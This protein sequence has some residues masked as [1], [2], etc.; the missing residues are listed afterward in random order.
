[1]VRNKSG[2]YKSTMLLI[3]YSLTR[4]IFIDFVG[5]LIFSEIIA[6]ATFPFFR[7]NIFLKKYKGL[8]IVLKGLSILLFFQIISDLFN[9]TSSS[10]FLRGWAVIFF[11]F[12]SVVFLVKNIG[13]NPKA[14][15]PLLFC[16][17][18]IELI[19]GSTEL[20]IGLLE[21]N[22]NFFKVRF[23]SFL[24]L[25]VL[26]ISYFF[27]VKR[28][29]SLVPIL[30]LTYALI[31]F[32][33]DARSNGLIFLIASFLMFTKIRKV[34][35]SKKNILIIGVI[36][37]VF[38]YSSYVFYVNSVINNGFGGR[39]A[40]MQ[41]SS[42][43]NPYNPF[44]LLYKG[45][46]ETFIAIIAIQEKPVLGHGSWAKDKGGKYAYLIKQIT[47]RDRNE[48]KGFIPSHSVL[49]GSWLYAGFFGF[50][51]ILYLFINLFK[52]YFKIFKSSFDS[53]VFPIITVLTADMFWAVLF[54]PFGLL[55]TTFP[56]FAAMLIIYN[57]KHKNLLLEKL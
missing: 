49:L 21:E 57:E 52:I 46:L 2:K 17:F 15:I 45:R 31:C 43:D 50:L 47:G 33:L 20:D 6:L 24:N 35:F 32:I 38:F 36:S 51:S 10:D 30:F 53:S 40:K 22:S 41:I 28:T 54:S 44:E 26:L 1:M 42:M 16:S 19:F 25:F 7:L 34:R 37:S 5:R 29:K 4:K 9:Q 56:L 3:L 14:I 8:K 39:N 27:Y 48:E 12:V 23:V 11:S 13:N 18:L 55:R